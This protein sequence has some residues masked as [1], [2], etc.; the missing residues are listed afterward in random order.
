MRY[1]KRLFVILP[2]LAV[3]VLVGYGL[4][5]TQP[6]GA[7]QDPKQARIEALEQK[8]KDV[9]AEAMKNGEF[10]IN[11]YGERVFAGKT[12]EEVRRVEKEVYNEILELTARPAE[13]RAKTVEAITAWNDRFLYTVEGQPVQ[14][15]VYGGRPGAVQGFKK[16][17]AETYYSEDYLFTVDVQTN[18]V[19]EVYMRPKEVGEPAAFEDMTPRYNQAQLEAMARKL[20]DA[21]NLG[22]DLDSLQLERG[23][24]VGTYFF[25]WTGEKTS[26][27]QRPFIQVGLTQGGQLIGYTN[28]G[29]FEGL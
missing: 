2:L 27:G 26:E 22:V 10:T 11:K 16:L 1:T 14:H 24:K 8:L 12:A 3:A 20:V 5:R 18:K 29:F 4:S 25:R 15:P 17:A 23:Q 6:V 19:L 21:Q 7:Q 13:D 9:T 28:A